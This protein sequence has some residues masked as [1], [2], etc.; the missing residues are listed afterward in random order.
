MRRFAKYLIMDQCPRNTN[1]E[2]TDKTWRMILRC[3]AYPG[4]RSAKDYFAW[5]FR[6]T[7]D[8][9]WDAPITD[10]GILK[11]LMNATEEIIADKTRRGAKEKFDRFRER[12]YG[13]KTGAQ[14]G[15]VLRDLPHPPLAGIQDL[16]G[17]WHSE[18]EEMDEVAVALFSEFFGRNKGKTADDWNQ[19]IQIVDQCIDQR[20]EINPPSLSFTHWQE[21]RA[22][23]K[24]S[25][26]G[27]D[28]WANSELAALP[29]NAVDKLFLV[30][31]AIE[32]TGNWPASTVD[33]IIALLM[34]D[35]G[36]YVVN[37]LRPITVLASVYRIWASLRMQSLTAWVTS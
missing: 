32:W 31:D 8:F 18:L 19:A 1:R 11:F 12:L 24:E 10:L 17:T 7:P 34:K 23:S 37:K 35:D 30:V 4:Y 22:K 9:G 29:E 15:R 3:E 26:R 13:D 20:R 21:R 36:I 33:G 16:S 25:Q 27:W 14:I 2:E 6:A 28:G 5:T